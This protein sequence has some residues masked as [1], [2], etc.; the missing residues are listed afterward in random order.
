MPTYEKR[1][2]I[3][4]GLLG[5]AGVTSVL[6]DLD[7]DVIPTFLELEDLFPGEIKAVPRPTCRFE[8]IVRATPLEADDG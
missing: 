5:H 3:G 2:V 7:R 1:T 6:H 8:I 4:V